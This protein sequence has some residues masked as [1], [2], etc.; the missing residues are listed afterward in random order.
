M[1]RDR[2]TRERRE[3]R[4]KPREFLLSRLF[5]VFRDLSSGLYFRE[6]LDKLIIVIKG[7]I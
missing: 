7:G 2:E 6:Q 3:R 1:K 5:R 4:E